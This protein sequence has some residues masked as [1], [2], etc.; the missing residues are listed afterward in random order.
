MLHIVRR[1]PSPIVRILFA[2][3]VAGLLVGGLIFAR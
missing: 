1:L 2:L 3:S